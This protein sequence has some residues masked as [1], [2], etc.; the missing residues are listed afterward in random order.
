M[1]A[2]GSHMRVVPEVFSTSARVVTSNVRQGSAAASLAKTRPAFANA[3]LAEK[4]PVDRRKSRRFISHPSHQKFALTRPA[5]N[6]LHATR[7]AG[8][9]PGRSLE[10][11]LA[12]P[13][14]TP[15]SLIPTV[16]PKPRKFK[17]PVWR[18]PPHR[19]DARAEVRRCASPKQMNCAS[20]LMVCL[21]LFPGTPAGNCC[22]RCCSRPRHGEM[23]TSIPRHPL[24]LCWLRP[25]AQSRCSS[26]FAHSRP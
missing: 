1:S 12:L 7:S 10:F 21:G 4:I 6:S 25:W 19:Q 18:V 17:P 14:A 16:S 11:A 20:A 13:P 2:A 5:R 24:M 23:I 8:N 22:P 26:P 3:R 9:L 15:W